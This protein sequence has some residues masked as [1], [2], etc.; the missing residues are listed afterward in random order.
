MT[1][2]RKTQADTGWL[3]PSWPWPARSRPSYC[4]CNRL[5]PVFVTTRA[6]IRRRLPA[7]LPSLV[8]SPQN[9][10]GGVLGKG[11]IGLRPLTERLD[12]IWPLR[13]PRPTGSPKAARQGRGAGLCALR[14]IPD[15]NLA[16]RPAMSA[17]APRAGPKGHHPALVQ[18]QISLHLS[19]PAT[20]R[21]TAKKRDRPG[22]RRA[23]RFA[24]TLRR[25]RGPGRK[26]GNST[27]AWVATRPEHRRGGSSCFGSVS[28]LRHGLIG[29]QTRGETAR[30]VEV[31]PAADNQN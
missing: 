8:F 17:I 23:A 7:E 14:V 18:C 12:L 15:T 9:D 24:P 1:C 21:E 25:R 4:S 5:P 31:L 20:T 3:P 16:M 28:N 27:A 22:P 11:C 6:K 26:A 19:R 13:G 30:P 2:Q 29:Q 10:A